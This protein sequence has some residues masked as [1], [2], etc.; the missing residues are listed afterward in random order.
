[1]PIINIT[2]IKNTVKIAFI[3]HHGPVVMFLT[4]RMSIYVGFFILM[5]PNVSEPC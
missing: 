5:G 1:M 4:P 3:K 2:N